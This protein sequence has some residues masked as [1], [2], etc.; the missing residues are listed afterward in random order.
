[1]DLYKAI[2]IHL[3]WKQRLREYIDGEVDEFDIAHV[4]DDTQ[5]ELG[6]WIAENM[7][8]FQDM[9]LFRQLRAEHAAFHQFAGEVVDAYKAYGREEAHILLQGDY[10]HLSRLVVHTLVKL[11]RELEQH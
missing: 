4:V 6:H 3:A 9:E 1:M 7:V 11:N 2:E 8:E 10:S 5:C